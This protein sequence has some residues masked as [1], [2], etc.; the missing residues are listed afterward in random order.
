MTAKRSEIPRTKWLLDVDQ[1][2]AID[3]EAFCKVNRGAPP[4]AGIVRE[5][6]R[7]YIA[8]SLKSEPA[9]E[10]RYIEARSEIE[11]LVAN[12]SSEANTIRLVRKNGERTE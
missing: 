9:L 5:A 7:E 3:M 2:L 1:E 10:K 4:R 11:R 8:N 12:S 6:V